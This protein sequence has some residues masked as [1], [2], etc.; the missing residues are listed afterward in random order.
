MIPIHS[1][2][3]LHKSLPS[4]LSLKEIWVFMWEIKVQ[5]QNWKE[6]RS[7]ICDLQHRSEKGSSD[8]PNLCQASNLFGYLACAD[9]LISLSLDEYWSWFHCWF[10]FSSILFIF[11]G[12]NLFGWWESV[13]KLNIIFAN[14][15]VVICTCLNGSVFWEW[16][17]FDLF[18]LFFFINYV[19]E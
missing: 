4:L 14:F 5:G 3:Y 18:C 1:H 7:E 19:L 16:R 6:F 12:S 15:F 11:C 17:V 8:E 9:C 2:L 10:F 13:G